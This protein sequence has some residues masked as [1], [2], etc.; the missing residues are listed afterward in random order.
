MIIIASLMSLYQIQAEKATYDGRD[1]ILTQAVEMTHPAGRLNSRRAVVQNFK[2][3]SRKPFRKILL[4]GQV[5]VHATTADRDINLF[6]DRASGE[7]DA[8]ALFAFQ[9]LYC[10]GAVEISTS[11]GFTARG[12][13][14][15]FTALANRNGAIELIPAPLSPYCYLTH[16]CNHLEA[17]KIHLDLETKQIVC[18]EPKGE[19]EAGWKKGAFI[20][21]QAKRITWQQDLL[22]EGGVSFEDERVHLEAGQG[23]LTYKKENGRLQPDALYCDGSVR[24]I[25]SI[26][27]DQESFA[28]ADQMMYLPKTRT[29]V[30]TS[31]APHRVLFWQ[32]SGDLTLS[33]PEIRVEIDQKTQQENVLGVGDVHF[34]FTLQEEDAIETLFSKYL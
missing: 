18:E 11:D 9:S 1:L 26:I 12:G 20:A 3:D 25:S 30:L 28:L 27:Q 24:M 10:Q 33:A 13:E 5:C 31:I 17:R 15:R 32:S 14:A 16:E 22:L 8:G 21:F 34:H 19:I 6:A 23:K 4:E 2:I 29:I 7:I